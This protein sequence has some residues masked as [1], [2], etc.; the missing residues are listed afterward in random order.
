[1][2][3]EEDVNSYVI[4][5]KASSFESICSRPLF[6]FYKHQV[7]GRIVYSSL[8][9]VAARTHREKERISVQKC[10]IF[11][12]KNNLECTGV[13]VAVRQGPSLAGK[14]ARAAPD[15]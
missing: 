3:G 4:L 12:E 1:M 5:F 13:S 11:P 2:E 9:H 10:C 6:C 7:K 8:L 15:T 14:R